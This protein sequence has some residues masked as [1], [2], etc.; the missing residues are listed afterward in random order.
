ME[1]NRFVK[2]S[3]GFSTER[4]DSGSWEINVPESKPRKYKFMPFKGK[5][6][7]APVIR[8]TPDDGLYI[9]TYFSVSAFSPSQKYLVV[10]K[11][12]YQDHWPKPG[13][14]ADVCLIDL[15]NETIKTIYSTTCWEYQRGT[16]AQWGASDRHVYTNDIINNEA[17]CVRID[18]ETGEAKSY[19]GPMYSVAPDESSVIAFPLEYMDVTQLGYGRPALD[20]LNPPKLPPGASKTQGLWMT[21]LKSN[22]KK[23][24]ISIAD[25]ANKLPGKPPM[26]DFTYYFWHSQFNPQGNKIYTILRCSMSAPYN[27]TNPNVFTYNVDG[28]NIQYT[29]P[30]FPIWKQSGGHGNW[31]PNGE[32][33]MR[34]L[35]MQDGIERF[36]LNKYDGT[37][38]KI[39]SE[40]IVATGHNIIE[41]KGRFVVTDNFKRSEKNWNVLLRLVDLSADKVEVVCT[42][43]T[44]VRKK[45][46]IEHVLRLDG[47]PSWNRDY[48]KVSMQAAYEGKRQ[49]FI[50]DLSSLMA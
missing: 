24:L 45:L 50:V 38:F 39:L 44:L 26:N 15:E 31:H 5:K 42:I 35:T 9:Q 16:N 17:V 6:Q 14:T 34:H 48:K 19:V 4:V 49:L 13:D 1:L 22:K 3:A 28:S 40:K 10:S 30:M 25:I 36:C 20:P 23:L 7:L 32:Y 37:V 47:H 21:D 46:P 27:G 12:P 2:T 8:V 11:L 18:T 41:P 33:I 43:P 29:T